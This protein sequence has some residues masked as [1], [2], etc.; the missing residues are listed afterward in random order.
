MKGHGQKFTRSRE[1]AIAAL[2]SEH[3]VKAAADKAGI[4]ETTLHRWLRTPEF[5]GPYRDARR[6]VVEHALAQLQ[7]AAKSAVGALRR[8]MSCGHPPSEIAAARIVLELSM[9]AIELID[10]DERLSSLESNPNVGGTR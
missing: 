1:R 3:T 6:R 7:D 9:R 8:N 10:F 4:S 5:V 2:L